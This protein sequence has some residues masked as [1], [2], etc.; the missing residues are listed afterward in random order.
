MRLLRAAVLLIELVNTITHPVK[1]SHSTSMSI[2]ADVLVHKPESRD[3][4][5]FIGSGYAMDLLLAGR[6]DEFVLFLCA[7]HYYIHNRGNWIASEV[8]YTTGAGG[9]FCWPAA[10][11]MPLIMRAA[12]VLEHPDDDVCYLARVLPRAWV[13]TGDK[14][15]V[16][17]APTRWE[18]SFGGPRQ[19]A[20]SGWRKP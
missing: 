3:F 12:L 19:V 14:V 9:L 13:A 1:A 15:S 10:F 11:G 16:R 7:H 17:G 4:L 5:G 6:T 8:F 20:R 18:R 2:P